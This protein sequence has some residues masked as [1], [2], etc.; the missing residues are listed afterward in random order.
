MVP[1]CIRWLVARLARWRPARSPER[2]PIPVA[3]IVV[4]VVLAVFLGIV[5]WLRLEQG[6]LTGE[7]A[8]AAA[9][10][11]LRFTVLPFFIFAALWHATRRW[12]AKSEA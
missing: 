2:K 8:R 1:A 5:V 12:A 3:S 9:R 6:F 10:Y 7:S 4:L 11:L